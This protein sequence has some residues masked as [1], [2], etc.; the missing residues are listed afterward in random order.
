MFNIKSFV[1][2]VGQRKKSEFLGGIEPMTS[3][4]PV[5][6]STTELL[7]T[8]G[9]VKPNNTDLNELNRLLRKIP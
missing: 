9:E 8:G 1:T 7:G 4:L 6:C 2:S 3:E 5:V